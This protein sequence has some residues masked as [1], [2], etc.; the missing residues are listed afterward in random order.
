MALWRL[1]PIDLNDRTWLTSTV[2]DILIVRAP[3]EL[4]A[5]ET[6]GNTFG[7]VPQ[8]IPGEDPPLGP[9]WIYAGLVRAEE[10]ED[11]RFQSEGP[12]EVL[13]PPEARQLWIRMTWPKRQG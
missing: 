11:D 2:R 7:I 10:I 1:T 8:H 12:I 13:D 6:A 9:P 5:R 3:D 4:T